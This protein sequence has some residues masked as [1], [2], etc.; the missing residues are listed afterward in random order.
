MTYINT[1]LIC[2]DPYTPIELQKIKEWCLVNKLIIH[3]SKTMQLIFKNAQKKIEL[4][5]FSIP[6]YLEIVD[7]TK[8][9]GMSSENNLNFESRINNI[10]LKLNYLLMML[11]Y[12]CKFLD[13][14]AMNNSFYTLSILI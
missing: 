4:T 5:D 12:L 7:K 13:K 11:R 3:F 6:K 1:N 9:L 14:N 2:D 10:I 8:F